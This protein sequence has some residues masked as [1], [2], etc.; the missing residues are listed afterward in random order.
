MKDF[1]E[2]DLEQLILEEHTR[3]NVKDRLS[4]KKSKDDNES[5]KTVHK[6]NTFELMSMVKMVD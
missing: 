5:N 3:K 6:C 1:N 4:I 2:A